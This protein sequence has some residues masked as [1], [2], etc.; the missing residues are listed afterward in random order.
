MYLQ[1]KGT[2]AENLQDLMELWNDGEVMRYVGFPEGLKVTMDKMKS[3]L[4]SLN[5]KEYTK[6]Y[7]LLEDELGFIGETFY[8]YISDKE[9]AILDIKLKKEARGKGLAKEALAFAIDMLFKNT[10]AKTATVDP[11]SENQAAINLYLGLGFKEVAK[12]KYQ[13]SIHLVMTLAKEDWQ[14]ARIEQVTLK[15]VTAD[16]YFEVIKLSV[17]EDQ[18]HFVATNAVSLV[19]AAYEPGR[20]PRAIY[21]GGNIVGFIMLTLDDETGIYWVNR[22]MIDHK[23]QGLGYARRAMELGLDLLY[24]LS[25]KNLIYISFEPNNDVAKALYESLGFNSTGRIEDGEIIYEKV[26]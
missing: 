2:K 9:P 6:H 4:E 26:W 10:P 5:K 12:S 15:E 7:S 21:A 14:K 24:L 20:L 17:R 8:S 25:T 3:W 22:L 16:N 13:D 11:H 19:Q 18:K 1:C 23:F